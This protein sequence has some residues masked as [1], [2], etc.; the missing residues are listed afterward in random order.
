ML[1]DLEKKEKC[2]VVR[3]RKKLLKE[4]TSAVCWMKKLF[5]GGLTLGMIFS[6]GK[7]RDLNFYHTG[8]GCF[9]EGLTVPAVTDPA[10]EHVGHSSHIAPVL[11]VIAQSHGRGGESQT[12]VAELK[13]LV[14]ELSH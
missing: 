13:F 12:I 5:N 11:T 4:G 2:N 9:F 3:E 7:Q 8:K 6:T 10:L 14:V 1:Q